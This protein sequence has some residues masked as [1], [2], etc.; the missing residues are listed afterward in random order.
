MGVELDYGEIEV[1]LAQI[2]GKEV[3]F[4]VMVQEMLEGGSVISKK[5]PILII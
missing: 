2:M 1:V 4:D 3:S 5:S